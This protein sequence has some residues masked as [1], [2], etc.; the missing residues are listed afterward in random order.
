VDVG[1]RVRI[2]AYKL[3]GTCTRCW[4]ATVEA[5]EADK[6]VVVAPVGHRVEDV[7]GVWT[8]DHA[9]RTFYWLDRWFSLLEVYAPGGA[10]EEI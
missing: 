9:I 2:S 8:S 7:S 5:V 10:L 6:A 3:D 4:H 1:D